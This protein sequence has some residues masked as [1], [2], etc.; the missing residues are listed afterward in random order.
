MFIIW[1]IDGFTG[2]SVKYAARALSKYRL[3]LAAAYAFLQIIPSVRSPKRFG[4]SGIPRTISLAPFASEATG[5]HFIAL[6]IFL[7]LA[8][9]YI[10]SAARLKR[11]AVLITIFEQFSHFSA[12]FVTGAVANQDLWHTGASVAI[13]FVCQP[14]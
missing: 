1:V 7:S 9:T 8:L 3:H 6:G 12:I 14:A 13:R 11:I 2:S 10:D 4:L 5:L